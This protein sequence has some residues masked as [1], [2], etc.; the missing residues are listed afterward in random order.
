MCLCGCMQ[1]Y[2]V[3]FSIFLLAPIE[4][5]LSRVTQRGIEVQCLGTESDIS[6][7]SLH[8][9]PNVYAISIEKVRCA[10]GKYQ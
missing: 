5:S 7:C 1:V 3:I 4:I 8:E 6:S 10:Y 9:K 2:I